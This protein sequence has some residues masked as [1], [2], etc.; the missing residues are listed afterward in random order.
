MLSFWN[1]SYHS[2]TIMFP[3]G[4]SCPI[5]FVMVWYWKI[6][7]CAS[8]WVM[9]LSFLLAVGMVFSSWMFGTSV[10]VTDV[11]LLFMQELERE[12]VQSYSLS[13]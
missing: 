8:V 11:R 3:L 6:H 2:G 12:R 13:L 7:T 4:M 10:V 5:T 1:G 9:P